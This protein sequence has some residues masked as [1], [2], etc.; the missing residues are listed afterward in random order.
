MKTLDQKFETLIA[1]EVKPGIVVVTL[2]RPDRYNAMTNT[3]FVELEQL[4]WG[5][6]TEDDCRVV[7]LTGAGKAFCS[8]YDLADADDLPNLGALGMLDQ[9]ERAARALTAI[10][11]LRVPVIAAVNGAAAGGGFSLALAADIRVASTDA[12]FNAAFVR[13]G[14]S[15]GDLGT[16]WLLTRLIGPAKTSEICFTGRIVDAAEAADLG[17]VNSLSAD[18]VLADSLAIAEQILTNSPGGVQLSKRALQANLEVGSYAAALELENRGQALL[19]RSPD[20]AEALSAFKEK[21]A[22]VFQ[23]R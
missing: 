2:N 14:L 18:D 4:A 9:Q 5:L 6:E 11:S 16:S 7:I 15:A 8:G 13:I 12:K 1:D 10:R 21:R 22:P 19:T 3:M 23:G 20:M 17:L